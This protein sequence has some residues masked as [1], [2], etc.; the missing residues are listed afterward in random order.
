MASLLYWD[1]AVSLQS[2]DV[3][4]YFKNLICIAC[5]IRIRVLYVLTTVGYVFF[6]GHMYVHRVYQR[7]THQYACTIIMLWPGTKETIINLIQ[8]GEQGD[9]MIR[10]SF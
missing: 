2:H 9:S 6:K 5:L 3:Q 8:I 7:M 10:S 1:R 4:M